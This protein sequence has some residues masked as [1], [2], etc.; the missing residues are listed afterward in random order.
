MASHLAPA[1]PA[2]IGKWCSVLQASLHTRELEP[3][4]AAA[5]AEGFLIALEDAPAFALQEAVRRILKAKS[6][7]S[8]TFVPPAPELRALVDEISLPAR[9]HAVQLRRLLDAEVE[10]EPERPSVD[11]AAQIA[12]AAIAAL[13]AVTRRRPG[14]PAG[15]NHADKG[16][17]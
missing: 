15:V 14:N 16:G 13:P 3:A 12:A 6:E 1:S 9:W 2:D 8:K 17:W 5:N 4:L 7:C 10:R 11:R